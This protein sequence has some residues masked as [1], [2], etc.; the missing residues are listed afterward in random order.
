MTEGEGWEEGTKE[1]RKAERKAPPWKLRL[2]LGL[3]W[4]GFP[5]FLNLSVPKYFLFIFEQNH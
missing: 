1:G 5:D 4:F 2:L 3:G